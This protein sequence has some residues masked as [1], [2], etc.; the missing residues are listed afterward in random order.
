MLLCGMGGR[1][2]R[3]ACPLLPGQVSRQMA[4]SHLPSGRCDGVCNLMLNLLI[5]KLEWWPVA[6]ESMQLNKSMHRCTKAKLYDGTSKNVCLFPLELP[7]V[8]PP[9][10]QREYPSEPEAAKSRAVSFQLSGA[11]F[12]SSPRGNVE[13]FLIIQ[14][15]K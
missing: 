10:L 2:L 3:G 11:Y 1:W 5:R 9:A 6:G 14:V 8:N 15:C 13:H 7:A 4:L 12:T